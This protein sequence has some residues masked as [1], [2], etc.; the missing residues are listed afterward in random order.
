MPFTVLPKVKFKFKYTKLKQC[1]NL[2]SIVFEKYSI[3]SLTYI[4]STLIQK[5]KLKL[6]KKLNFYL[7]NW[8]KAN[9]ITSNLILN[10]I[11]RLYSI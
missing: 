9:Y 7:K 4:N 8:I 11:Y 3:L 1:L 2:L 5:S 10:K 6:K